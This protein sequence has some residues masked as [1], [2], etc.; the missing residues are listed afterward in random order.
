MR[1]SWDK[2]QYPKLVYVETTNFCDARCTYCLYDRMERPV[3]LMSLFDF[4]LV[5]DKVKARGLEIGAV[6]CF[7]EPLAD[8]QL[9]KKIRYGREIGVLTSY[10]GINTNCTFLTPEKYGEILETTGNMTLSFPNTHDEFERLTGLSWDK[11]YGNAVDFIRYRD[12]HKPGF[13]IQIGCNDVTGHDRAR[14]RKAFKG[15]RVGWARDA[16]IKWGDKVITGVIDRS[17]MYHKWRCD[18][19]KGALQVKPNGDCCFCAYD[20]IRSETKFANIFEDDWDTIE[21]NFKA[22]WREP[23]SLCLRCEYWWNYFQMVKG[24]WKRGAH[25]D[26]SWQGNYM[27]DI[28][29]FWREKHEAGDKRYLSGYSGKNTWRYLELKGHVQAASCVLNVGVGTG[30]CTRDLAELGKEVH[31]LDITQG[32]LDGVAGAIECGYLKPADLPDSRFDLVISHL[33]AQHMN[34]V[35]LM[36]QVKHVLRSLVPGGCFAIQFASPVDPVPY[37]ETLSQQRAGTVRRTPE[38][39]LRLIETM[40]GKVVRRCKWVFYDPAENPTVTDRLAWN[41]FHVER[42]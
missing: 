1:H 25:I 12:K 39:M 9:F 38:H 29:E 5:A 24:G 17:I 40:G 42:R 22:L 34:D 36:D 2:R 35:D 41:G 30:R 19:H 18:G 10:L 26:S 37:S 33:V 14:V 4:Q 23:S 16:E 28:R 20:V 6:F 15:F 27:T 7:G 3:K 13:M 32:A 8:K 11:C 21:K 31:A